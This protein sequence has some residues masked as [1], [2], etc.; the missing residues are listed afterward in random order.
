MHALSYIVFS[1]QYIFFNFSILKGV[2]LHKGYAIKN[3]GHRARSRAKDRRTSLPV[4]HL[5]ENNTV[6]SARALIHLIT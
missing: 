1:L 3:I 2:N 4:V 5:L 6:F